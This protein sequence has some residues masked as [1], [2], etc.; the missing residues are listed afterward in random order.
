MVQVGDDRYGRNICHGRDHLIFICLMFHNSL[1]H[2]QVNDLLI[3]A[4]C[5][6]VA[7]RVSLVQYFIQE[8]EGPGG[9]Q[10]G[11]NPLHGR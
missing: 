2:L 7:A 5:G 10:R 8:N 1:I 11:F 3:N 6:P 9:R 4:T